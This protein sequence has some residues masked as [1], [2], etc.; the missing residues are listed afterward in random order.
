LDV[1]HTHSI[2]TK[3]DSKTIVS[4]GEMTCLFHGIERKLFHRNHRI[5]GTSLDARN[6]VLGPNQT[7]KPVSDDKP[8]GHS[9][10]NCYADECTERRVYM[11]EGKAKCV[12]CMYHSK[13]NAKGCHRDSK[14]CPGCQA[15][16]C[17]K[18]WREFDHN[19]VHWIQ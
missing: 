14:G 19:V 5:D 3:R 12:V 11:R 17:R 8:S 1:R 15:V 7:I 10:K 9:D 2:L 18:H 6:V 4:P 16:V 13:G